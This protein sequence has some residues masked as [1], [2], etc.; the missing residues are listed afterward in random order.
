[1]AVV[2]TVC[3]NGH[4]LVARSLRAT[5]PCKGCNEMTSTLYDCDERCY[6]EC[7]ECWVKKVR[8]R[9]VPWSPPVGAGS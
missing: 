2:N 4:R 8:D 7:A 9:V 5:V 1:M 3:K 6:G